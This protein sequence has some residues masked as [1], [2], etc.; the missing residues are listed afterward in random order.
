VEDGAYFKGVIELQRAPNRKTVK[1]TPLDTQSVAQ[2]AK[3]AER[4]SEKEVK[5]GT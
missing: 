2:P 1:A 4:L 3:E 5:K